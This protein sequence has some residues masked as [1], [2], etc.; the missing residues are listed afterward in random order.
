MVA[1]T[2]L[3]LIA[4]FFNSGPD[5]KS[6]REFAEEVKALTD[7]DKAEL[8]EGIAAIQGDTVKA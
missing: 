3:K 6:V 1:K 7:A 2:P 4:E 8:A 5:K